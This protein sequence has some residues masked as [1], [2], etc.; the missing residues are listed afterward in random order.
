MIDRIGLGAITGSTPFPS[1]IGATGSSAEGAFADLLASTIQRVEASGAEATRA[2]EGFLNGSG[3][4]IH[5]TA[6][7]AQRASLQ[8]EYF[9]QVR[10][11]VVQAYQEIMRMQL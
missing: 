1:S 8:F 4:D 6:L 3:G 7:A 9:M 5:S 10:N 11:K 2:A